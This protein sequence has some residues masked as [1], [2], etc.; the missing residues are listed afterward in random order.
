MS[1]QR[2]VRL[3]TR[4]VVMKGG[5]AA[6]LGL[7]LFGTRSSLTSAHRALARQDAT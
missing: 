6:G 2:P 7:T 1:E 5:A 3:V 4:R